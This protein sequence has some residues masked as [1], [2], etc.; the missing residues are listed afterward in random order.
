[1]AKPID[2]GHIPISIILDIQSI[3]ASHN[4]LDNKFKSEGQAEPTA[5]PFLQVLV[6][7]DRALF[8]PQPTIDGRCHPQTALLVNDVDFANGDCFPG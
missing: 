7:P 1:M 4:Q 5:V 2:A 8:G 6:D 3:S